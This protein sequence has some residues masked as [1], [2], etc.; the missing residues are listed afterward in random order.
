MTSLALRGIAAA[1]MLLDHVGYLFGD[2]LP[3]PAAFR[4]AGRIAMPL[5]CFLIAEGLYHTRDVRKYL[6][7]LGA[8][9]LLS[10]LPYDYLYSQG[11]D[12]LDWGHQ[13]VLFTLFLGLLGI[14]LFDVFAAQGRMWPSLAAILAAAAGAQLSHADYGAVG[15]LFVF[16]CY[17][18]RGD[19]RR[20]A[21]FFLLA[22][23]V[24]ASVKL[25]SGT[26]TWALITLCQAAALP[27]VLLYGGKPGKRSKALQYAVYFFYPAHMLLL[28]SLYLV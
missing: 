7:R 9:A 4:M 18:C 20:L 21:L 25:A 13:N 14:L 27:L 26:A 22:V 2:S 10:E 8:F 24:S 11:R 6:L 1:A 15:V 16:V 12:W 3:Y 23:L 5:F 17:Y 28:T 19:K